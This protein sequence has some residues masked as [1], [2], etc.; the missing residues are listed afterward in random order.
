MQMTLD[1]ARDLTDRAWYLAF[2]CVIFLLRI[3]V[4]TGSTNRPGSSL[5]HPSKDNFFVLF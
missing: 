4:K 2:A 5:S 3:V 1:Q